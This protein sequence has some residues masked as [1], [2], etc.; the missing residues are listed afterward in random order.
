VYLR[1]FV[2]KINGVHAVT[3]ANVGNRLTFG[4]H[5]RSSKP[6]DFH[7]FLLREK[8]QQ[9]DDLLPNPLGI[10]VLKVFLPK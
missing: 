8:Q 1:A 10:H 3:A 2:V 6:S 5:D 4:K 9:E 7:P